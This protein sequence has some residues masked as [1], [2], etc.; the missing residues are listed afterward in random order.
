MYDIYHIYHIDANILISS[1]L[2]PTPKHSVYLSINPHASTCKI[3]ENS[4]Y[5]PQYGISTY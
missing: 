3:L 5:I 2:I 1:Q 4:L